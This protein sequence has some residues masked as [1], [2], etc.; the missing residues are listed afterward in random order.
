MGYTTVL[1]SDELFFED[2]EVI[3][4]KSRL[5]KQKISDMRNN[6][7][8]HELDIILYDVRPCKADLTTVSDPEHAS[9][10]V[11]KIEELA[12]SVAG[13]SCWT[14]G[15][16][17]PAVTP[18]VTLPDQT[19]THIDAAG[20][21]RRPSEKLDGR[22]RNSV[23]MVLSANDRKWNHEVQNDKVML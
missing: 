11:W 14:P 15:I 20:I 5:E 16:G 22:H 6:M 3:S 1:S 2:G 17:S 19:E 21:L 7:H 23:A 4:E 8:K 12:I 13:D 9:R 18:A 10:S